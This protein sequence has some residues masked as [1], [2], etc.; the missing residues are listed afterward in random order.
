MAD[1]QKRRDV[2]NYLRSKKA[3]ILCIQDMHIEASKVD[4]ILMEWG[5][6]GIIAPGTNNSR[7]TGILFNNNFQHKIHRYWTDKGGNYVIVDL[8]IIE[9][10]ITL[11][12]LYGPNHDNQ[13]MFKEIFKKVRDI[14]NENIIMVGDWNIVIDPDL[15]YS[16]QRKV[17]NRKSRMLILSKIPEFN[18]VDVWRAQHDTVRQYTWHTKNFEKQSRLDFFLVSESLVSSISDSNIEPGYRTDHS[19]I[20]IDVNTKLQKRGKG[21]WKFNTSLLRNLQYVQLV[22]NTIKDCLENYALLPYNRLNLNDM[23]TEELQL[24]IPWKIFLDTLLMTIR[25]KTISFAAKLKRENE[26]PQKLLD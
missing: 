9:K 23:P 16:R 17:I 8:T 11:V 12:T 21:L 4:C 1:K 13:Q 19:I 25:G 24:T 14:K 20:S 18:L 15:D 6:K 3:A 5:L 22:Q 2:L 7:G 10:R 26:E